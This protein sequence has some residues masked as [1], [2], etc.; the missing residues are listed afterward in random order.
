MSQTAVCAVNLRGLNDGGI[1]R[2][3]YLAHSKNDA[4]REHPLDEHLQAVAKLAGEFAA[5]WGGQRAVGATPLPEAAQ[6]GCGTDP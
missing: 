1:S 2:M 3:A 4:G 6:F 5:A